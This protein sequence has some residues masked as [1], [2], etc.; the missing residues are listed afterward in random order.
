MIRN[1]LISILI[2]A[3]IGCSTI[4]DMAVD[5]ITD[6]D[7]GIEATAQVGKENT[8]AALAGKVDASN[9]VEV[10]EVKGDAHIGSGNTVTNKTS[11]MIG[12][13]LAGMLPPMVLL[14]YL[15]PSPRWLQRRYRD[16]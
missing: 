16:D 15:L 13:V 7:K 8:K 14:F 1:V 12:L 6:N 4:S 11:T 3:S 2:V 5:A 10:E 9:K